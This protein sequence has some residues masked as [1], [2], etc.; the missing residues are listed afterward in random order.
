MGIIV[1]API[2]SSRYFRFFSK[3]NRFSNDSVSEG[4]DLKHYK[5][6]FNGIGGIAA[7]SSV[8]VCCVEKFDSRTLNRT[9][10]SRWTGRITSATRHLYYHHLNY[11][12]YY[13]PPVCRPCPSA[14]CCLGSGPG[15]RPIFKLRISNSGT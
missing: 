5:H 11:H 3:H 10:L 13:R 8:S 2:N 14:V 4:R 9:T 15:V 1:R 12:L 7:E 6:K